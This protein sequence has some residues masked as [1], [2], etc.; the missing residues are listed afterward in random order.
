MYLENIVCPECKTIGLV[1][2]HGNF[3]NCDECNYFWE[4]PKNHKEKI[5]KIQ[6]EWMKNLQ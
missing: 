5:N 3:Y 2:I 1:L 6:K 4:I